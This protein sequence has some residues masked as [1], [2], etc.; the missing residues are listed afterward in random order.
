MASKEVEAG[1]RVPFSNCERQDYFL[2]LLMNRSVHIFKSL[3]EQRRFHKNLMLQT[4]VADRFR[5]LYQMQQL[6]KLLHPVT[7]KSRKILIRKW[8]S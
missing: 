6:T 5:K 4:T 1:K 8:T 7:D 3:D 2:N